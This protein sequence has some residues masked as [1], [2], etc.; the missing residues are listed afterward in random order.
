METVYRIVE[1]ALH[2]VERHAKADHVNVRIELDQTDPGN[3]LLKVVIEDNGRGFDQAAPAPG[4]FGLL[5][6]KEQT[7]ILSGKLSVT[8]AAAKGTRI[9]LEVSI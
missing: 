9:Q 3:H 1:E 7:D 5:G 8:S 2:N 4:H 6:M